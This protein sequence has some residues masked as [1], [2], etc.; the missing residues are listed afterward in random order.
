MNTI[1]CNSCNAKIIGK[2]QL[3]AHWKKTNH[4]EYTFMNCT[5]SL[6]DKQPTL[7]NGK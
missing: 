3:D 2:D 4:S 6:E 5:L 7:G 1:D